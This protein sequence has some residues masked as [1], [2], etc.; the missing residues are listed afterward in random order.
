MKIPCA[1]CGAVILRE[2]AERN[3][4]LCMPCRSGTRAN[5]ESSKIAAKRRREIDASDPFRIYWR[6]LVDTVYKTPAG[7]S[8]LSD[9][10]LQYWAVGCLSGEIY[11]GGFDQ[12][13]YNSSGDTY[14]PAM[15]GLEAMKALKSRDLLQNAKQ[16]IFGSRAVP[17]DTGA[18][19]TVLVAVQNDAL[20]SELDE[21]DKQFWA[22]PDRLSELSQ[23]F[24]IRHGL[25]QVNTPK[26]V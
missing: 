23:A 9:L 7:L 21:L 11:N 3:S 13:F 12:Y 25:V 20:Q 10:E 15:L 22:D 17:D 16:A 1:D 4:G 24:A 6:Q 18:R 8:S 5:I 26:G 2:T 19:R 14:A